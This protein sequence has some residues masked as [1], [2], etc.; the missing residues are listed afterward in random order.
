MITE[1]EMNKWLD[2]LYKEISHLCHHLNLF[3]ELRNI[4]NK[5]NRLK[6]MDGTVLSW[7]NIS[8][9]VDMVIGMGRICDTTKRTRSLVRFLV[10]LK[11]NKQYLTRDRYVKFYKNTVFNGSDIPDEDFNNLAGEDLSS[12]PI[13]L[14]D[15]DIKKLTKE[16]PCK[17]IVDFRN[18]Y[19]GHI[20][21]TK[22][23]IP[24]VIDL[25]AAFEIIESIMIKYDQLLRGQGD[26]S[27]TPVIQGNWKQVF[28]I[29]WIKESEKE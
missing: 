1:K 16:P 23:H 18:Q 11:N 22:G 29:P 9:T 4:V 21:Q 12:Y 6:S 8:F 20:A 7:M 13:N 26:M 5:N 24:K 15:E 10:K 14:I 3:K 25:F 2:E 28:T 19:I 27:L 17:K